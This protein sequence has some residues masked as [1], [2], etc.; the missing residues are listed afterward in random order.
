[1]A[2]DYPYPDARTKVTP[3]IIDGKT[4]FDPNKNNS[5]SISQDTLLLRQINSNIAKIAS[6][7]D[8]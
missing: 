3:V 7:E 8:Y 6:R 5:Q 2:S 1:M 4:I